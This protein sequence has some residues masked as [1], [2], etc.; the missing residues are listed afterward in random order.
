VK[1]DGHGLIVTSDSDTRRVD[2]TLQ[3]DIVTASDVG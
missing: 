1:I 2:L 3:H